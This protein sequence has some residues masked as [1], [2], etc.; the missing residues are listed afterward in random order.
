MSLLLHIIVTYIKEN[1]ITK[2]Q[3][4]TARP[5]TLGWAINRLRY[6]LKNLFAR[7]I[8]RSRTKYSL[9]GLV[10]Q[11]EYQN[12]SQLFPNSKLTF[13]EQQNFI[14]VTATSK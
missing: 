6:L 9:K 3:N 2:L 10:T 5:E 7:T 1:L 8:Y 14:T 11:T 13:K 12:Y 4:Y